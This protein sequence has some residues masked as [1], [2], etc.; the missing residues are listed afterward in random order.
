MS[1]TTSAS[2]STLEHAKDHVA[3]LL[4]RSP[5]Y[6]HL[7]SKIEV[8]EAN[9][10]C[11]L[12]HLHLESIHVNSLGGLHGSV[13]CTLID[14]IG[15]LAIACSDNRDRTGVS[16]D[17]HISFI[18]SAKVGDNI[19]I[20]GC[21]SKVGG[22]LAFTEATIRKIEQGKQRGEGSLVAT[23]SHTKFVRERSKPQQ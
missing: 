6:G 7:F 19:E 13:S 23:G 11:V 9:P 3:R 22:S 8:V 20:E 10:K 17:M 1:E 14:F 4:P 12:C 16:V 2:L 5:L 18:G 21:V 15:G